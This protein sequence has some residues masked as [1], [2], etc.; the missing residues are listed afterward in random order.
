[1][2]YETN[3]DCL[4]VKRKKISIWLD[5][6]LAEILYLFNRKHNRLFLE[7]EL[8]SYFYENNIVIYNTFL[9]TYL[10][11]D[12]FDNYEQL[13]LVLSNIILRIQQIN[14]SLYEVIEELEF[15]Q[16]EVK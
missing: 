11:V 6:E 15:L 9:P 1:M 8:K 2:Y 4:T 14:Q 5:K 7:H 12:V 10:E 3:E 13:T 16:E